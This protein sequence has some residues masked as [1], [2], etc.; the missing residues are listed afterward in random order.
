MDELFKLRETICPYFRSGTTSA[1]E[2]NGRGGRLSRQDQREGLRDYLFSIATTVRHI[3]ALGRVGARWRRSG[4]RRGRGRDSG[5]RR[6]I[7][8]PVEDLGSRED[9]L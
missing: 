6:V 8:D 1:A 4:R 2:I 9:T 5:K 7:A 3:A